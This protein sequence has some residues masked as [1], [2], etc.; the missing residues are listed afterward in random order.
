MS[1]S[2]LAASFFS[3]I[4]RKACYV[5][6]E[7]RRTFHHRRTWRL[8]RMFV[9]AACMAVESLGMGSCEGEVSRDAFEEKGKK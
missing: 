6:F 4:G 7:H 8:T 3:S 9:A 5:A 1:D 2:S